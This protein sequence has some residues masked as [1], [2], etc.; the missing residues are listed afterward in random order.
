MYAFFTM[1][2]FGSMYF[3]VPRLVLR[4]WPS[5]RLI[6]V[7]FWATAFGILLYV[8]PLSVGGVLQGLGMNDPNVPFLKTVALTRPY[9]VT[10]SISG[11]IIALGH[12]AFFCNFTWIL[13]RRFKPYTPPTRY[14]AAGLEQ[15]IKPVV[16]SDI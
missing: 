11:T 2:M 9:L 5:A 8:A 14:I 3:I 15:E 6:S 4:E 1:T 12:V 13:A 7:H 16:A 10:R